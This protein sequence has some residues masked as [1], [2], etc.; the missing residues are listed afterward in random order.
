MIVL[1]NSKMKNAIKLIKGEGNIFLTLFKFDKEV[2]MSRNI[3][4][5]IVLK[6]NKDN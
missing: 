2:K 5:L 6:E 3:C 1:G 4:V